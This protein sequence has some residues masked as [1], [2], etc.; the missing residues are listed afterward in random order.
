MT[1]ARI[2]EFQ[3]K[4]EL[5]EEL[6]TFLISIVPLIKSSRGCESVQMYQ[7]QDDPTRFTMIEI[8][9]SIESHQASVRTI[10]PDK[11]AQ[12]RPLL[13]SAPG[14]SYYELVSAH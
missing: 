13:G 7:S 4:P 14:G 8:W 5:N 10:P 12:I 11:L 2:G 3:A 1:V 9:D 6:R